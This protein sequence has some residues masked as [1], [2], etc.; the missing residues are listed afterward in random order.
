MLYTISPFVSVTVSESLCSHSVTLAPFFVD[1]QGVDWWPLSP[2]C[3]RHCLFS[4]H[5]QR[6]KVCSVDCTCFP[7]LLSTERAPTDDHFPLCCWWHCFFPIYYK[8]R[9]KAWTVKWWPL[10][11]F[12]VESLFFCIHK[13]RGK[14]WTVNWWLITPFVGWHCLFSVYKQRGKVWTV[15]WWPL[16]PFVCWHSLWISNQ[17][18]GKVWTET[19]HAFKSV[20]NQKQAN[21]Q[22]S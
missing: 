2:F 1:S 7:P 3:S 10:S 18:R 15:N 6:G 14:V 11:P 8:Q 19:V 21:R 17:Q 5:R 12:V 13:Q 4:I 16:S 9:G 20:N 22:K